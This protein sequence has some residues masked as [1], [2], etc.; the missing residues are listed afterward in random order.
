M[1]G[2]GCLVGTDMFFVS[3][4]RSNIKSVFLQGFILAIAQSMIFFIYSVGFSFGA[5]LIVEDRTTFYHAFR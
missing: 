5:F 2:V 4:C 1:M 3:L